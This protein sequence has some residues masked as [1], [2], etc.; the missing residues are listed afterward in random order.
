MKYINIVLQTNSTTFLSH[1]TETLYFVTATPKL[2][3][4]S[5]PGNHQTPFYFCEFDSS[6][7]SYKWNYTVFVFFVTGLFHL[8]VTPGLT[9]ILTNEWVSLWD[10]CTVRGLG[11]YHSCKF[12]SHREKPHI[13]TAIQ[14]PEQPGCP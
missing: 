3:L 8:C 11:L 7:T 14:Q 10:R 12:L 6:R 9:S 1:K 4:L 5:T 13:R 2:S